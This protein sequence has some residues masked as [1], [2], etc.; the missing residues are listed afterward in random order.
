MLKRLSGLVLGLAIAT[1]APAAEPEHHSHPAPEHLGTVAFSTTCSATVRPAFDRALALLHSFSYTLSEQAFRD[2]AVRDPGCA[3]AHWGVA[4]SLYHQL[5]QPPSGDALRSGADEARRAVEG[6]AGSLRERQFIDAV[7]SYYRDAEN[8]SPNDRA[9]RYAESMAEV[10]RNNPTDDEAQSFYA[11]SLIATASPVDKSHAN[12]RRAADILEPIFARHPDHPGLAHYLIHTYDSAELAP[13]GVAAARAYSKIA[14]SAPHALHM[15]S[16]VFTRLGL[17]EDSIASNR[18]A[19]A[20]AHAQ[21]D[22]GEELHAMDYLTYAYLQR[23]R[24]AE[25]EQ[26]ARDVRAL[27]DPDAADFKV[28][29]AATAIPVRVAIERRDWDGA[30]K[31]EGLPG[32]APHVAALVYWAR[33]VGRSRGGHPLESTADIDKLEVSLRETQSTGIS[34]WVTQV[35]AL[36]K[37]ARAW[38]SAADGQMEAA[39]ADLRSAADEEDAVEKLPVTPGPVVPAREPLGEMLLGLKRP[40]EALQEFQL[41]L[42]AAPGRRGALVGAAAAAEALGDAPAAERF[43]AQL[44]P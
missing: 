28:G 20:A 13:R 42:A 27:A 33:A 19:R 22:L 14:P 12:Q 36:L 41:A 44:S 17:W 34:Y 6:H 9:L 21:G 10:A 3:I 7:A 4:M 37:E 11:L 29:Y 38:R 40:R 26:V 16:H 25:A 39:L 30:A 24:Y 35:G 8:A 23:A 43:R 1:P 15:P 32:L 18:A 5:W 2:V 31:L